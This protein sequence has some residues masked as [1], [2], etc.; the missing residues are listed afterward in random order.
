MDPSHPKNVEIKVTVDGRLVA[1]AI[2][3]FNLDPAAA[4]ARSIWF[5]ES[6]AGLHHQRLDLLDR[7][8]ILRMRAGGLDSSDAT[9]KLRGSQPPQLRSHWRDEFEIE[10]DWSGEQ[11]MISASLTAKVKAGVIESSVA[12]G[13]SLQ[14][15]FAGLQSRY[16]SEECEPP[17]GA[18]ELRALGPIAALKWKAFSVDGLSSGVRAERWAV[19]DLLF[20]EFS[21]RV[22]FRD[23]KDAQQELRQVIADH[24]I[25]VG[26]QQAPKTSMVLRHL[27]KIG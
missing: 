6:A 24:G 18:A 13:G 3:A 26:N 19:D 20:L 10:G 4:E 2:D 15:V 14:D 17:V 25:K 1:E 22:K 9:V 12:A 8:I 27:A 11:K 23:G 21:I 5:C 16:L 7:G